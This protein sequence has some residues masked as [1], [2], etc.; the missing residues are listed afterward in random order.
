MSR[1]FAHPDRLL[2]VLRSLA[3]Q[4]QTARGQERSSQEP[5]P[6]DRSEPQHR[7]GW[8]VGVEGVGGICA[9]SDLNAVV[10]AIAIRVRERR[11][12]AG[13]ICVPVTGSP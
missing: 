8:R 10:E 12:R 1:S 2:T 7:N 6:G 11:I 4:S 9:H 13:V 3:P 5:S